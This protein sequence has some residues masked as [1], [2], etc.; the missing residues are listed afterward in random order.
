MSNNNASEFSK[1]LTG[2]SGVYILVANGNT[3]GYYGLTADEA[4]QFVQSAA[5]H[6]AGRVPLL[7]G[8]G[9]SI[10]EARQLAKVS[11]QV[12]YLL[13]RGTRPMRVACHEASARDEMPSLR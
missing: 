5:Q 12:G 3:D 7:A 13:P 6:V 8:I 10:K 4:E 2:I 9:R 11:A 1:A